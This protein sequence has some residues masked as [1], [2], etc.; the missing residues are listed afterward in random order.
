MKNY[1][2]KPQEKENYCVPSV[3]QA[4]FK[5]Y[6]IK[7]SQEDIAKELTPAKYG[8]KIND[9]KFNNFLNKNRFEFK[10]YSYNETP[11]NEP[12]MVLKEINSKEVF[13]GWNNHVALVSEFN[14]PFI[15][16]IDPKNNFQTI[17]GLENVL[18]RMQTNSDGF[19]GIVSR[20][21][22]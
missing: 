20:L 21:S 17:I 22:D 19:F 6:N 14:D 4:I 7:L 2:L 11:F 1:K 18:E 15:T 9:D 13:I 16:Y 12:D 3:L 5:N 8:F 10:I